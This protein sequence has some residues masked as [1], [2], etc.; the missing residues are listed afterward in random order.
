M[1]ENVIGDELRTGP[2]RASGVLAVFVAVVA[3][4]AVGNSNEGSTPTYLVYDKR[5]AAR[6]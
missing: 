2:K 6:E 4:T 1:H 5:C 3:T